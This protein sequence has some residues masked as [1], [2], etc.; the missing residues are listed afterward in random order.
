ME[1]A[2]EKI[3]PV[4]ESRL[5]CTI[6]M[7]LFAS[8]ANAANWVKIADVQPKGS[9]LLIDTTSVARVED[10]RKAWFRYAYAT[11]RPIP[12]TGYAKGNSNADTFRRNL[13]LVYFN[14]SERSLAVSQSVLTGDD[15]QNV[16]DFEISPSLLKYREVPPESIGERMLATVC[17]WDFHGDSPEGSPPTTEALQGKRETELSRSVR[18]ADPLAVATRAA[19]PGDYYPSGSISRGEQGA[20]LVRACV[21]PDGR[22]LREPIVTESSGFSAL[23]KAGI[24]VAKATRY[25]A[26]MQNGIPLPESCVE[27]KVNFVLRNY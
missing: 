18:S 3:P 12:A 20:P 25:A 22:L 11:D 1:N 14:C 15:G 16:G 17:A 4:H 8:T 26:G 6:A 21:G 23:D 5:V 2:F 13:S 7:L 19:N 27:F 24:K 9:E 10:L